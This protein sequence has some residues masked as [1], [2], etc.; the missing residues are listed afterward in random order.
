MMSTMKL[1]GV[2]YHDETGDQPKWT[3]VVAKR[4][5]KQVPISNF[6]H[7]R[8]AP[9]HPIHHSESDSDSGSEVDLSTIIPPK[10]ANITS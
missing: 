9:D 3:P 10:P 5:K 1:H 2:T 7:H 8:F 6:V 4:K